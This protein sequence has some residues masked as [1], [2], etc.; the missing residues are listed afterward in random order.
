[1]RCGK[2]Q[3]LYI[4]LEGNAISG[5]RNAKTRVAY[6]DPPYIGQAK[7]LYNCPE[8]DHVALI[9]QLATYDAWALSCSSPSLKLILPMC[10]PETRVAAWVKPFA[11]FKPNVNPAY[12]WEPVLFYGARKRVR[13]EHTIRDWLRANT[14][15]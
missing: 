8:V 1:M 2:H 14:A 13:F 11:I 9:K 7:A 15:P 4:S 10:P 3:A 5:R 6:A 12:A